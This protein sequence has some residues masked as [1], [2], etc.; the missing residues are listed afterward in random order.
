VVDCMLLSKPL[1][2][3][4]RGKVVPDLKYSKD[5]SRS[6]PFQDKLVDLSFMLLSFAEVA[7]THE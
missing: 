3:I 7:E 5:D 4:E 2:L 6:V 1:L